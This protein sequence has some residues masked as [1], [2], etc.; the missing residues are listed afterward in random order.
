MLDIELIRTNPQLVK[1]NLAK[2]Q[3]D[4]AIID[5]IYEIDKR[6]REVKQALDQAR[7]EKNLLSQSIVEY[8]KQGKDISPLLQKG[9]ELSQQIERLEKEEK[10]LLKKRNALL[11][12]VPNLLHESVPYGKDDS[13]NV[14][15]RRW[16]TPRGEGPA[17]YEIAKKY[18]DAERGAKLGGHRFTVLWDRIAKLE[19]ALGFFMVEHALSRGYKEVSVPH[20]VRSEIMYG[21]G[22]LPKFQKDLYHCERDDLY[23]IP[24]AEVPLTNLHKNEILEENELPKRYVAWTPCYRREAG[25]YGRDIKGLMRQHQFYKTELVKITLPE[26]SWREHELMVKDAESV[27]QALELPYRVV[28][29]CSGDVGFCSAKTYD[30]EVWVPSQNKYREIS[31]VSNCTDFQARRIPIKFRR[32]G[33]LEYVHTLN[34]SGVA[35]GRALLALIEN[36][37]EDGGIKIPK[38]LQPYMHTDFL[39]L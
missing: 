31:S 32:E 39:E 13:E 18:I 10:E 38:A 23:L 35:V 25:E 4:P 28:L 22:Q 16:G 2:R 3:L 20:L 1:E 15:V 14:E 33:K 12:Q 30:L 5:E 27:L 26:E 9:K 8:R 17:H 19:R 34:G 37:Y 7:R 29:L 11:A 36:H 6:W 24:T 21:T